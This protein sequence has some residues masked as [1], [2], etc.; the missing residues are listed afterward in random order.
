MRRAERVGPSDTGRAR[1]RQ[2][3][4]IEFRDA[5][6]PDAWLDS[7]PKGELCTCEHPCGQV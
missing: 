1:L 7:L 6:V 4:Y 3:T 5:E 2:G